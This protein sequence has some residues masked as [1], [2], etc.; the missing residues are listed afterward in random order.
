MITDGLVSPTDQGFLAVLTTTIGN[1]S[2]DTP[3]TGAL[4]AAGCPAP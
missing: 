3:V 1:T 2:E 4:L